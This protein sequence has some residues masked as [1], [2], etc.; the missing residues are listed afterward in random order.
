M[1][2]STIKASGPRAVASPDFRLQGADK[3]KDPGA[4]VAENATIRQLLI[5]LADFSLPFS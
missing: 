2:A 1:P 4:F 3:A 5:Q